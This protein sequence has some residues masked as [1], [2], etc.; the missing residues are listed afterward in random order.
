MCGRWKCWSNSTSK[1][2]LEENHSH[3]ISS[4]EVFSLSNRKLRLI[5]VDDEDVFYKMDDLKAMDA[6][7]VRTNLDKVNKSLEHYRKQK[8]ENR[9]R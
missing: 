1:R 7:R 9:F 4:A 2:D 6:E 8:W 5:V 3:L